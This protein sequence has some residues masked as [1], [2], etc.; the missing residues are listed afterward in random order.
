M[1]RDYLPAIERDQ[2]AQAYAIEFA[3]EFLRRCTFRGVNFGESQ[4]A[5]TGQKIAGDRRYGHGFQVCKSC[6]RVQDASLLRRLSEAEVLAD[7]GQGGPA[8]P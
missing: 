1:D 2:I 3:Y 8:S 4:E 7:R 5:P 6:G